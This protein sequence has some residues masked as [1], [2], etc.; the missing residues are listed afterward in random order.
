LLQ[1][2]VPE[3]GQ[4]QGLQQAVQAAGGSHRQD[5]RVQAARLPQPRPVFTVYGFTLTRTPCL[6]FRLS[7]LI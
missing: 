1:E 4:D 6:R 5:E 7:A 2:R 3:D